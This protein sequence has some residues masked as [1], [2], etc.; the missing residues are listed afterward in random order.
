MRLVGPKICLNP[1]EKTKSLVYLT[2]TEPRFLGHPDRAVVAIGTNR[3]QLDYSKRHGISYCHV[4]RVTT[5]TVWIGKWI[6]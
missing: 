3:F 4:I 6:Y 5:D 1:L 2:G